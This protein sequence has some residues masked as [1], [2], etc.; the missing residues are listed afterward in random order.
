MPE[1]GLKLDL[2]TLVPNIA[3]LLDVQCSLSS[4]VSVLRCQVNHLKE[5][6]TFALKIS[7]MDQDNCMKTPA[8]EN[9]LQ[10]DVF[11]HLHSCAC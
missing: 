7:F 8:S 2:D 5:R 4:H 6:I 1:D 9:I 3:Q 10:C 11:A